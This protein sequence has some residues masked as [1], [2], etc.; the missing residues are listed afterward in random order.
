MIKSV[1]I[2][3]EEKGK[4]FLNN[5]LDMYCPNVK[6]AGFAKT[7]SSAIELIKNEK[8]DLVFLDI[9]LEDGNSF[10]LLK[11]LEE[12][13]FEVVFTTAHNEFAINAI[14]LSALDYLVKPINIEELQA[15]VEK[16]E[17]RLKVKEEKDVNIQ[18]ENLV[19]NQKSVNVSTHKIGLH[20]ASGIKFVPVSDIY[21]LSAEG[22]YTYV[23]LEK[24]KVLITKTLKNFEELLTDYKFFRIHRSFLVNLIH[25]SELDNSITRE[26]SGGQIILSNQIHVPVSRDKKKDLLEI[27]S[28]PF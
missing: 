6:V 25:I 10:E 23:H 5:L 9:I 26:G 7:I 24:E 27:I 18:L 4:K 8:P 22:N 15:A 17:T 16:V 28:K 2:E 11:N 12:R 19:E 14:K 3:D 21:Y 20:S 1:I 13:N